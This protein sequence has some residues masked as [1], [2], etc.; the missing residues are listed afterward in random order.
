M[1]SEEK[2]KEDEYQTMKGFI[3]GEESSQ[4][5]FVKRL[6]GY[7][8]D[9]TVDISEYEYLRLMVEFRKIEAIEGSLENIHNAI[10]NAFGSPHA[11]LPP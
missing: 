2:T 10:V 7:V 11:D 1:S 5:R 4:E 8:Q 3:K 6:I 9:P